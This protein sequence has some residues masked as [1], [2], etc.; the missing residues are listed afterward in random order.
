MAGPGTAILRAFCRKVD[1]FMKLY[2]KRGDAGETSLFGGQAVSKR[3][4]RVESYGTIDELNS[5]LGWTA[6]ACSDAE[7]HRMLLQIQQRLM[8]AGSDLATPRRSPDEPFSVGT[9]RRI[10]V[11]DVAE[12]EQWIDLIEARN[13]PLTNFILPG[14]SE[15]SARLH[16]A[17]TVARRAER[18][19]VALHEVEPIGDALLQFL[20]RLSDLF[21]AQARYANLLQQVP[22]VLWR[23]EH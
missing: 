17:R 12:L 8:Q 20:N 4:L 16:I 7:L 22:D 11:N 6:S 1:D 14:G 5:V 18:C 2:T 9:L 13:T 21:F 3:H 23:P 15:L 19:C 10:T